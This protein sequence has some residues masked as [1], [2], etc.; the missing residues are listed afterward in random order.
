MRELGRTEI[1]VPTLQSVFDSRAWRF[2][3]LDW[4]QIDAFA[5]L[6]TLRDPFDRLIVA[7]ARATGSKLI[8]K[9]GTLQEL[10]LVEVIWS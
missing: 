5:A 10:G 8:S 6:G 9:D 1:G 4:A 2:L 3:P 7:A